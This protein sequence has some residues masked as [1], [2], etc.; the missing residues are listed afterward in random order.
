MKFVFITVT[1][2]NESRNF[3]IGESNVDT[4]RNNLKVFYENVFV[5]ESLNLR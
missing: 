1:S 5:E 2:T 4:D 3:G